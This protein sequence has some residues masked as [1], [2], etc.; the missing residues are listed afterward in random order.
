MKLRGAVLPGCVALLR[1][2]MVDEKCLDDDPRKLAP[3]PCHA[4]NDRPQEQPKECPSPFAIG[5]FEGAEHAE[6]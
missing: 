6:Q 4:G 1:V 2:V 5:R 3:D